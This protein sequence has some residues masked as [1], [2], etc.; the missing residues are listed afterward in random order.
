MKR[1][2]HLVM[3][4][5]AAAGCLFCVAGL[6]AASSVT[7][8][9]DNWVAAWSAPPDS[10][11][12]AFQAQTLRQVLRSSVGGEAVRVR[13]S[14]LYGDR[15]LV[16]GEVHMALHA[17]GSSIVPGSDLPLHFHGAAGTVIARGESVLSDPLPM[18]VGALQ[19]LMVTM[20]LPVAT[21]ASTSHGVGNQTAYL[22]AGVKSPAALEF[23]EEEVTSSRYFLTDLEVKVS[24]RV[25][26]IVILGDSVSDGVG[27]TQDGN[28]R[29]PDALADRL[30]GRAAFAVV[31]EGIAGNRILHDGVSL[32]IGS[33]ALSRMDR[34]VFAKPG[35][36]WLV[37]VEG[38][39]DITASSTLTVASEQVTSAQVIDGMRRIVARAHAKGV[40]VLAGTLPPFAGAEWPFHS[41]AG[42]V[43]RQAVNAWIRNGHAFDAVVDFDKTLRDPAHPDHL[44]QAFDSGD[45][46]HPNDAGHKALADAINLKDFGG[47]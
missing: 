11:G 15:P 26:A 39:N 12:P 43:K 17:Q 36:R 21:G 18:K 9:T 31:N 44:L 35:V 19:E 27:S 3:I 10:P 40:K 42:E 33:S 45:H 46:I 25:A 23:H 6:S 14:N 1:F 7:A 20:T 8:K 37:L 5:S 41:A 4:Q 34:D 47:G 38:T 28:K 22:V 30:Q 16:I 29:W 2:L 24:E 32:F 13:L